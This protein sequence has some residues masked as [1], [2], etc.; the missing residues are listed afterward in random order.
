MTAES[1]L[2]MTKNFNSVSARIQGTLQ[3]IQDFLA[4][5]R[6]VLYQFLEDG[7]GKVITEALSPEKPLCSLL[8][9][10]FPASDIP[11]VA[12]K[13]FL[14]Q[15][16][17][18]LVDV[19]LGRQL[20]K[21]PSGQDN[22][23]YADASPCYLQYLKQLQIKASLT[24]PLIIRG[25]LW[26]LLLIHHSESRLW[27]K[28][29][30]SMLELLNERLTLLITTEQL[31]ESQKALV[32]REQTLKT[33]RN[34]IKSVKGELPLQEILETV[35]TG[36]GGCGGRIEKQHPASGKTEV[37]ET[38]EQPETARGEQKTFLS[39]EPVYL[40]ELNCSLVIHEFGRETRYAG[41]V[42]PLFLRSPQ[43]GSLMVFRQNQSQTIWWAGPPPKTP[44]EKKQLRSSFAPWQEEMQ[45]SAYQTWTR[46]DLKLGCAI[47]QLLEDSLQQQ[48]LS[49]T[50]NFQENYHP[51]TQLP[52][53]TQFTQQLNLITQETTRANELSAVIVLDLDRFQQVNNTLGHQAGD[54]LLQL[55]AERLQDYVAQENGFLAHWQGDKFVMLLRSLNHLDS[56]QLEATLSFIGDCFDAPFSLL[57]HE[58]YV[59]ASWG[60]AISPYDGTDAETLLLNAET[61]MYSAK[62][63]GKN[64]Y[65][66]YTPSLRSPLNPLTLEAEIRHSLQNEDFCLYYQPQMNLQSG[67][68]TAVEALVRW[69]HPQRGLLSPQYFIPFAEESD[70]ICELGTWVLGEACQ[71]LAQWREQGMSEIRIAVNVS[72]RQFQQTDFV[73]TVQQI[74]GETGIPPAALEIEITETTAA[75]NLD[76]TNWT[77]KQLQTL[78][79]TVALDDFGIGYSSLNAIKNFPLNTLKIDR[80]FIQDLNSSQIDSA[81]VKSTITLADG[82]N[83]RVVA[84]G[85]ETL[86]QLEALARIPATFAQQATTLEVQ[87]YFLSEPLA[88]EAIAEFLH[89]SGSHP[90]Q[91]LHPEPN[92][93]Q[94]GSPPQNQSHF[95]A[96]GNS[97]LQQLLNQTRREQLL[98]QMTQ[99]VHASLDLNE[100]FQVTVAEVRDFLE[101]DRVVLYRFDE[102][103][104][105]RV[106]IE[107][108]GENWEPLFD[109]EI[110]D[111]CF[112][113]KSAPLYGKGRV[114]AIQDIETAEM[115]AC[116]REMLQSFQVRANLV[117][118]ILNQENLWGLLIAH[119]CRS[120]RSW[121]PT[122]VSLLQQVA[123][124]VGVA[125]HQAELYQQLQQANQKLEALA[126]KDGLTNIANRR[127]FDETLDRQWQRLKRERK[128]L[129]LILCD[130]DD[131]KAYNDY[132]GHQMGDRCLKQVAKVLQSSANRSEDLVARYG[133]EEFAILLP[134]TP[135]E[136]AM[137]VAERARNAVAQLKIPHATSS[138]AAHV[139]VSLG[140]A[141]MIST[142][143]SSRKE[144]IRKADQAL[145]AAKGWGRDRA[146]NFLRQK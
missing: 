23:I 2:K 88:A 38:G 76:L 92:P 31:S 135:S 107:S 20:Q 130:I 138:V 84:E 8:G 102:D 1:N 91:S 79:V 37:Y 26:G 12:R 133:G 19:G 82:L 131:F 127:C 132:Y 44:E 71:Q 28:S 86:Q 97:Q 24:Y 40:P 116:Y 25:E 7:T 63:Q 73:E 50:L 51:L 46:E 64:R 110:D 36:L 121:H 16:V 77:L 35:V 120:P 139:T 144:L 113:V 57:G 6:V 98:A 128:P 103:W 48:E 58:I 145:Y 100:I 43:V 99:Q 112:Q 66:V 69:Q 62:E 96:I 81:I 60:V 47:A 32:H 55:V 124:Q 53:R 5:D 45:L 134:D 106:V 123:T 27:E 61:A 56:A 122:E 90:L 4:V 94:V 41:L 3:E 83:L 29:Q 136:N 114:L 105:G 65:Q 118:P 141:A 143:G 78:G 72:A 10:Q 117:L 33:L 111:P 70:L 52:N 59:K 68:I 11:Q 74:I 109:R 22:P 18:I 67:K 15:Q 93:F 119:H 89:N 49:T 13:R 30:L 142:E 54:Q 95:S 75:E 126:V 9:L 140:V 14:E 104:N 34:L 115:T 85:V 87:G 17:R 146:I 39:E 101:T 137:V 21:L 129:A 125:I 42:I 80:K 108:V